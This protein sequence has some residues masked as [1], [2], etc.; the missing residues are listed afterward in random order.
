MNISCQ[1]RQILQG[2]VKNRQDIVVE[3]EREHK[4]SDSNSAYSYIKSLISRNNLKNSENK[5][6]IYSYNDH[7]VPPLMKSGSINGLN[8]L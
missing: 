1:L 4:S 3:T 6:E 7:S 5:L 2:N 8:K